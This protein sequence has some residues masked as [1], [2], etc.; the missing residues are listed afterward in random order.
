MRAQEVA[1]PQ[2]VSATA[3]SVPLPANIRYDVVPH[4]RIVLTQERLAAAVR[5]AKEQHP[6]WLDVMHECEET[7][8]HAIQG[9]YEGEDW[10][11]AALNLALAYK[12]TGRIDYATAAMR[13]L[14]ALVDDYDDVGDARGGEKAVSG[15]SG[16]SIR[17]R[18]FLAAIAYDWLHDRLSPG[19][20]AHVVERFVSFFEWYKN[21]GYRNGD[22][23]SNH[24]MAYF[25]HAAMAGLAVEGDDPRG[26][27]MRR[28]ARQMWHA[29][30]VPQYQALSG[31][32][33]PEGWQ[34][35]R[36][37]GAALG[38]YAETEA[39]L[40]SPRIADELPWLRESIAFQSHALHPNGRTV[41][42]NGDWTVKPAESF[43]AQLYGVA[44]A[45]AP[46][47]RATKRALFLARRAA[48]N[49]WKWLRVV[50]DPEA[51][52][53]DSRQGPTSYFARGT[54]TI[55]ARTSWSPDATWISFNSGRYFGDHQHLDQGHFEIVRG[56]DA[57]LLDPGDYGAYASTSHNTLL[58]DDRKK[59]LRWT[60][61]QGVW[62]KT[63][64]ITRFEDTSSLVYADADFT[65]AYDPDGYP[66]WRSDRAVTRALRA[67][68]FA[69][70]GNGE[71][72]HLVV[73]D[74]VSLTSPAYGV[75]WAAHSRVAPR[76]SGPSTRIELGD[77][78]ATITTLL[79][80]GSNARLV[81]EATIE[82]DEPFMNNR[83]ADG[84]AS[85]RIE[86]AAPRGSGDRRFLHVIVVG[87]RSDVPP[88][89]AL[90]EGDGADGVLLGKTAYVFHRE[91]EPESFSYVVPLSPAEHLLFGLKPEE[92]YS[93]A[94]SPRPEGT[95]KVSVV[96]GNGHRASTA[97]VLALKVAAC[98]SGP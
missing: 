79:P 32:D 26:A 73:Y 28:A 97:G 33:F 1:A 24:Y 38:L 71:L 43:T 94:F 7:T 80:H 60:P 93:A 2:P 6:A 12:V 77:S 21:H 91:R 78:S 86:I 74:R 41:F 64:Q 83:P 53:E 49:D 22:A 66:Q 57:L 37:P 92:R 95:C 14:V 58:V 19:V 13:Y 81:R 40:G 88:A 63:C 90:L 27:T 48:R 56:G 16:Y 30:I 10:A 18:G 89:P 47:E 3:P 35:A 85:T 76:L 70:G 15:N 61:N 75:T 34:Y 8:S 96:P 51:D 59:H 39:R 67:L 62:C 69:R 11:Q 25:G 72:P 54:G 46:S 84:I 9:G 68:V 52:V 82:A 23:I 98:A 29:Q 87:Q 65:T 20:R 31:G 17:N 4:P 44:L 5:L 50:A 45:L 55:L 42:D 36:I